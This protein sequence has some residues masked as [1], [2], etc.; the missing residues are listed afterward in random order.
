MT[1]LVERLHEYGLAWSN[2]ASRD[3]DFPFIEIAKA[4]RNAFFDARDEI[5]RLRTALAE[6]EAAKVEAVKAERERCIQA[7]ESCY[8]GSP[9]DE[10]EIAYEIALDRAVTAIRHGEEA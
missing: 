5:L 9:Y 1:D 6:A 8:L 2:E 4:T 10:A 3:Y 7:V